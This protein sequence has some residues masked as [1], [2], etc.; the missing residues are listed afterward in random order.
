M[1]SRRKQPEKTKPKQPFLLGGTISYF[2]ES[3]FKVRLFLE[4]FF[5][6]GLFLGKLFQGRIISGKG[7]FLWWSVCQY[8]SE[9]DNQLLLWIKLLIVRRALI[10]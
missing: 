3:F 8:H 4:G 6:V 2:W 7:I 9:D 1:T 5:K 10:M